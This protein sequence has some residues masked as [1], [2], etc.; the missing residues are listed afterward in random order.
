[1]P[2]NEESLARIVIVRP[3]LTPPTTR[4]SVIRTQPTSSRAAVRFVPKA[5]EIHV[6][7][8]IAFTRLGSILRLAEL[9]IFSSGKRKIDDREL[10]NTSLVR[11]LPALLWLESDDDDDD[12]SQIS[13][14]TASYRCS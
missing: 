12:K 9:L 8:S 11:I 13:Y 3:T 1:M 7:Q 5:M 14:G 6:V 10:E 2:Q 4:K